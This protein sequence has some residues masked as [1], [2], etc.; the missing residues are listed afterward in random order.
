MGHDILAAPAASAVAGAWRG[1][2][3][4]AVT[5]RQIGCQ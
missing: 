5:D 1:A 2:M 4:A 3:R